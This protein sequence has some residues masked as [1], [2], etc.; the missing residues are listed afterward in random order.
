MSDFGNVC[1]SVVALSSSSNF[2][3]PAPQLNDDVSVPLAT[4]V[5]CHSSLSESF[6]SILALSLIFSLLLL[7]SL[8][9]IAWRDQRERKIKENYCH[10]SDEST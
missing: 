7:S 5:P 4:T 3:L 8:G 9:C 1:L 6:C 10:E 2:H